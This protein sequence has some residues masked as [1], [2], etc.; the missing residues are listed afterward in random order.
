MR[1]MN[2]CMRLSASSAAS[3]ILFVSSVAPA[4][5]ADKSPALSLIRSRF[6][7]SLAMDASMVSTFFCTPSHSFC[8]DA[9]VCSCSFN[10]ADETNSL[11][12]CI[13]ASFA[14]AASR[15]AASCFDCSNS[16]ILCCFLSLILSLSVSIFL[17]SRFNSVWASLSSISA[18]IIR[19]PSAIKSPPYF[20]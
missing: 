15:F 4:N 3:D 7:V 9:T 12:L 16:G 2:F 11:P 20:C 13:S 17:V 14:F 10:A 5:C 18:L 1:L 19:E 8:N 6:R